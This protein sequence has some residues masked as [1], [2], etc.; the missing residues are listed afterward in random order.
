MISEI[1][2]WIRDII[3]HIG[4]K[5]DYVI[6]LEFR[7]G[8]YLEKVYRCRKCGHKLTVREGKPWSKW[9]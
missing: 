4:C 6:V 5:H 7:M 9:R 8:D 2:Y 1:Y 3:R